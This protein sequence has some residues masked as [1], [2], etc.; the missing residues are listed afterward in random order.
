MSSRLPATQ[1]LAVYLIWR[2]CLRLP[3]DVRVDYFCEWTAE[4]PAFF[5]DPEIR[6]QVRR[7]LRGLLFA[8]DNMRGVLRMTGLLGFRTHKP[9][10]DANAPS[11]FVMTMVAITLFISG[12]NVVFELTTSQWPWPTG[13][14]G[15]YVVFRAIRWQIRRRRRRSREAAW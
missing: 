9:K 11:R 8:V 15:A 4:L 2:S 5:T 1:R 12:V 10:P 6:P 3:E 13:I 7:T 14:L